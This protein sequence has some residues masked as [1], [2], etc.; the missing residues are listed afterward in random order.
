M[1]ARPFAI[2]SQVAAPDAIA[3]PEPVANSDLTPVISVSPHKAIERLSDKQAVEATPIDP[4][5][6]DEPI[7]ESLRALIEHAESTAQALHDLTVSGRQCAMRSAKSSVQ[8]QERLRLGARMLKAFTCQI[9]RI[10]AAVT[11]LDARERSLQ[12]LQASITQRADELRAQ[13]ETAVQETE[14]RLKQSAEAAL[15]SLEQQWESKLRS[16]QISSSSQLDRLVDAVRGRFDQ[17]MLRLAMTMRDMAGRVE[18]LAAKSP[19][20]PASEN[21]DDRVMRALV[22][23]KADRSMPPPE[24]PAPLR[25]HT[26]AGGA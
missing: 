26:W 19:I 20:T 13:Q 17:D 6:S 7:A 4:A 9:S 3:L 15:R 21:G 5:A 14:A 10:E 23:P 22:E 16:D 25:L 24:N 1:A 11:N 2:V 8:L 18:Q 12:R